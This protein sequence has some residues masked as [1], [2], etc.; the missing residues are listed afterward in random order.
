MVVS[1]EVGGGREGRNGVGER[2]GK[3]TGTKDEVGIGGR[4][5]R[6]LRGE[7]GWDALLFVE[8]EE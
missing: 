3:G 1:D 6:S 5:I 4:R 7:E 2:E 8:E